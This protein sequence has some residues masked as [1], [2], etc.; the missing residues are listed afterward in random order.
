MYYL[1]NFCRIC[2][3]TDVDLVDVDSDD[4][5]SIKLQK[6]LEECT[7]MVINRESL[8]TKICTLCIKK[9]RISYEFHN[10]CKR[11]TSL[12]Q[13]LLTEL[14]SNTNKITADN[15]MNSEIRVS[16]SQLKISQHN[17]RKRITKTERCSILK[18]L[19]SQQN[20]MDNTLLNNIQKGV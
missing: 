14:M 19:L 5:D 2:I 7:E 1:A 8:S 16:L 20:S 11:S 9:L 15:F 17:P 4:V 12:L 13:G 6:K 18:S 10:M 3:K